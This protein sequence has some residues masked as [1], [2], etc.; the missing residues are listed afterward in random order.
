MR[1]FALVVAS[2]LILSSMGCRK[3][4]SGTASSVSDTTQDLA[5]TPL[6][7]APDTAPSIR[8]FPFDQ[9]QEFVQSIR[10]QLSGIDQQ[11]ADLRSQAK[12]RG[13]PVS[14][15]ALARITATRRVVEQDLKRM[16]T[17]TAANWERMKSGVNQEM[18]RLTESIEAAQPK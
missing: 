12:S 2:C 10:Q 5:A 15:R 9:R 8:N 1:H 3:Q 11:I 13:G 6:P 7:A 4:Q 14:D 17:A 16:N 18:D